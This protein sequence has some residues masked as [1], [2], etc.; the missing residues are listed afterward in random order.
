MKY[1]KGYQVKDEACKKRECFIPFS[2]NGMKICRL[3]EM[4][5][6]PKKYCEG[7]N[8]YEKNSRSV[9]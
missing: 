4:G 8:N 5:Q 3:F 6:C 1:K 2:G 9:C 7:G